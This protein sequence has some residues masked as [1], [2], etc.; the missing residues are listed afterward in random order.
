MAGFCEHGNKYLG[1]STAMKLFEQL[2]NYQL[3]KE[4]STP[5]QKVSYLERS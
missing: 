3:L 5:R 1:S 4:D 2:S